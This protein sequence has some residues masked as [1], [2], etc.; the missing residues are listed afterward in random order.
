[1]LHDS[2]SQIPEPFLSVGSERDLN[3]AS[4]LQQLPTYTF[5]VDISCNG[6]DTI[7]CFEKYPLLPG[8]ILLEEEKFIG[9]ISRQ[10]MLEFLDPSIRKRI[11]TSG[12][13]ERYL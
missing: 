12:T 5:Q 9:I 7:K 2:H 1:M 10:K 13:P 11:I 8:V 6:W 4:T 3:L